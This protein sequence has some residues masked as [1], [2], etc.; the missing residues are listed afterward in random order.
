MGDSRIDSHSLERSQPEPEYKS[1]SDF[2]IAFTVLISSAWFFPIIPALFNLNAEFL[3][4]DLFLRV[5]SLVTFFVGILL[6]ILAKKDN[7]FRSPPASILI[8]TISMNTYSVQTTPAIMTESKSNNNRIVIYAVTTFLMVMVAVI[9]SESD[10]GTSNDPYYGPQE[11][12]R[13]CTDWNAVNHDYYANANDSSCEYYEV[14]QIPVDND[15]NPC[16]LIWPEDPFH[17]AIYSFIAEYAL[18]Y[19]G[20]VGCFLDY[21]DDL[22][23]DSV[24]FELEDNWPD[25]YSSYDGNAT[26]YGQEWLDSNAEEYGGESFDIGAIFNISAGG[27]GMRDGDISPECDEDVNSENNSNSS[28]FTIETNP[29]IDQPAFQCFTKYI[30]VFGLGVFAESGLTDS[31][32]IH[33]AS[34]LA[35][36]LDNDEDGVVDD[37]ALHDKLLDSDAIVPMFNS[38]GSPAEYLMMTH[39]Q[40]EGIGAVLYSDEVDPSQ[41]GRWGYDASVE[42]IMHTINMVGHVHIYPEAFGIEPDSSLLSEA[43]DVARGGQFLE[44]PSSYPEEAWYH[45][46]DTT[47]EYDCMAAEYIYWAQVTNMGILNDTETCEGIDNEWE[48]CSRELLESM[49]VLIYDLVTDPQYKLPQIAPDGI[50]SPETE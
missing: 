8:D 5:F 1:K 33:A 11:V 31:Q 7:E 25:S 4:L 29:N 12:I 48:P 13:G 3:I 41:T 34:V 19:G 15:T 27:L 39:Y 40:G 35:E 21:Y 32:V 26:L 24:A 36:L 22:S 37:A 16:D 20:T 38:E 23:Y 46:Y 45:Y 30:E 14:I 50:Y 42:E 49:D 2:V 18:D 6:L 28:N 9:I 17:A 43:M 44:I 10:S 47:C